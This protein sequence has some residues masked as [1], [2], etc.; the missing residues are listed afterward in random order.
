MEK[1]KDLVLSDLFAQGL[2][3]AERQNAI[4]DF[5]GHVAAL[6]SL[7]LAEAEADTLG[8][9]LAKILGFLLTLDE[10]PTANVPP[11]AQVVALPGGSTLRADE[12]QPGL[13]HDDALA[14]APRVAQGG[15]AVPGFVEGAS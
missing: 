8:L 7:S 13:T 6:A 2:A 5:V 3:E 11:T 4:R 14:Q 1:T 15:F 10:A 9:E 12:V